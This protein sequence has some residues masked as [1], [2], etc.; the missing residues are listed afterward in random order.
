MNNA[1]VAKPKKKKLHPQKFAM[2][3]G[4]GSMIMMFAG[5]TSGYVVRRSQG[6]WQV[7]DLPTLFYVSTAAIALSSLT[8]FLAVKAF[9]KEQFTQFRALLTTTFLLG[10]AFSVM[11]LLGFKDMMENDI[12]VDGNPSGSFIY[13]IAICHLLHILGGVVVLGYQLIKTR[14]NTITE[15]KIEGLEIVGTFWH[16][17]DFLWL[18]LFFF[19]LLFR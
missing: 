15:D 3:V 17:V 11:Q 16:F 6:N 2:W 7:F 14:K 8:Y 19:F 9:K 1:S 10:V 13:V 18:Y 4:I 5:F 12:R